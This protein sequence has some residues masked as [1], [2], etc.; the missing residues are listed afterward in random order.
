MTDFETELAATQERLER[1]MTEAFARA[2]KTPEQREAEEARVKLLNR[3]LQEI[4]TIR[5]TLSDGR[6]DAPVLCREGKLTTA[7]QTL[8]LLVLE[9]LTATGMQANEGLSH[10]TELVFR[11]G[12]QPAQFFE[13][14]PTQTREVYRS[15]LEY[16]ESALVTLERAAT[17]PAYNTLEHLEMVAVV[18]SP[19]FLHKS[20]DNPFA[21]TRYWKR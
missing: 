16:L 13:L 21:R 1:T 17:D 2:E 10:Y 15:A 11:Q 18:A 14:F 3:R 8:V 7:G 12:F 19:R 5:K 6:T 9:G 20:M 4:S